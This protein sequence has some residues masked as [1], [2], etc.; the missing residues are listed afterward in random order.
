MEFMNFYLKEDEKIE[1]YVDM[2]GVITDFEK[3]YEDLTGNPCKGVEEKYGWE[4]F[5]KPINEVG[6]EWW[7]NL[8]WMS[9]GKELWN[10]IKQYSPTI[11]T[12]PSKGE[13]CPKGK[14]IWVKREIGDVPIIIE[15]HKY[16]YSG[17][18]KILIDD[19]KQK[20][21]DWVDAG[22][23]GILHKS[24]ED[25]IKRLEEILHNERTER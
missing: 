7:A 2:D 22:G 1:L 5:W 4:H 24:A 13:D 9:D 16:K 21:I 14:K 11:L 17:K 3:G 23:I 20:I 19:T 25:T 12:A 18:N 10:Y 15:K 8:P 6:Y